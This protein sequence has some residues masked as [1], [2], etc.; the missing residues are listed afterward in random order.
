MSEL[1]KLRYGSLRAIIQ[2]SLFISYRSVKHTFMYLM[3]IRKIY[4][5]GLV[6][7]NE[8]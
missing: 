4:F 5:Y 2:K 6:V 7:Q 1:S 3:S 8:I